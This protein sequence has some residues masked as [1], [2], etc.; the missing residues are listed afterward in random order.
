MPDLRNVVI[1]KNV[2][3]K[4]DAGGHGTD[5]G[6]IYGAYEPF[7]CT[8][9]LALEHDLWVPITNPN[10]WRDTNKQGWLKKSWCVSDNP[11]EIK[12]LIT[13]YKD[14][15]APLAKLVE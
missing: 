8:V 1:V 10:P 5:I 7:H 4:S 2:P 6:Y 13:Y 3:V 15:R 12:I 14:G 9:D 11:D